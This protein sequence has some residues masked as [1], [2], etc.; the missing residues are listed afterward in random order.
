MI[1][2]CMATYNG[3]KYIKDQLDSILSQL[4]GNDEIIISDD[5][6]KDNTVKYIQEYNDERIKL[7]SNTLRKG[8]T[9]NFE[10]SLNHC[11]GDVIFLS[12]QDDV[13]LPNKI[14]TCMDVLNKCDLV[15][16][17][18][19]VVDDEL[20]II[21]DS[22]FKL[23]NSNKGFLK[24]IFR[25]SYLGCCLAFKKEILS[26]VLPIPTKLELYHDWWIGFITDS[27]YKTEFIQTPLM[28]FRRH[29]F[30]TSPTTLKSSFSFWKKVFFRV[31]L[32]VFGLLRIFG[33]K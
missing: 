25:S 10:N 32:L 23:V 22:Y 13:W 14:V 4:G 30:N 18:C 2:V 12:D 16:T 1:S 27:C 28:L 26:K 21:N 31:Q 33:V 9:G 5:G 6:S 17:N 29:S 3:E 19:I 8:V 24:N 7:I 15:V 11:N 20:N